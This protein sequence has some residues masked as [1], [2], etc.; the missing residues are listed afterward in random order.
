V[1]LDVGDDG[2][3]EALNLDRFD[4]TSIEGAGIPAD[5]ELQLGIY[6]ASVRVTGFTIPGLAAGSTYFT[7]LAG[8]SERPPED[9]LAAGLL[10]VGPQGVVAFVKQNPF[11]HVLHASPDAPA[12]DVFIGEEEI[13]DDL[14]FGELS[15]ALQAPPGTYT[16]DVFPHEPGNVRPAGTPALSQQAPALTAG[17]AYLVGATGLIAQGAPNALSLQVVTRGFTL[18]EENARLRAIHWSPDAPAVDLGTVDAGTFTRIPELSGLAYPNASAAA[19]AAVPPGNYVLGLAP[20]GGQP[21]ATF[22]VQANA[23]EALFGIA[24]GALQPTGDAASL[25]LLVIDATSIPWRATRVRP[26]MATH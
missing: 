13:V 16:F 19:G 12:V 14:S 26:S 2:D 17:N 4:A 5:T 9:P 21:I 3:F 22:A 25:E 6:A 8:L 11:V 10:V 7:I 15:E 24:I 23:G 18:D 1:A 20:A